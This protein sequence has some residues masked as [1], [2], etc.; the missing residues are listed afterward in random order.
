[1]LCQTC[2][3]K[4][5]TSDGGRFGVCEDHRRK[6]CRNAGCGKPT[7]DG[8]HRCPECENHA[9]VS[10]WKEESRPIYFDA[11]HATAELRLR[12][13]KLSDARYHTHRAVEV[14]FRALVLVLEAFWGGLAVDPPNRPAAELAEDERRAA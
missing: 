8:R 11:D 3:F 9:D 12:A 6:V 13:A 14:S 7:I 2:S 4:G 5:V 1:M 10:R